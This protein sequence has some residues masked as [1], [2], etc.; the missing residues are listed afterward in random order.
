MNLSRH[1]TLAELTVTKSK[2]LN[3][4]NQQQILALEALCDNVLEKIREH[5]RL[6]VIINSGFRSPEVNSAA[7]GSPTSQHLRGEAADIEVPTVPNADVWNFIASLPSFDQVIAEYLSKTDGK[8]GWIHVSY[9]ADGKNRKD[10]RS[11]IGKG[12]YPKGLHYV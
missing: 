1:F 11:C 4:P 12:N 5:Y 8:A 9:R 3:I 7:G 10:M 2:Y 6:P